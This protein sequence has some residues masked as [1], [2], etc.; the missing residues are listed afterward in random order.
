MITGIK[1]QPMNYEKIWVWPNLCM[2][3][4]MEMEGVRRKV[5][6]PLIGR[7]G[8]TVKQRDFNYSMYP[9]LQ[10]DVRCYDAAMLL[11]DE[12]D[13]TYCEGF[14]Y[15]ESDVGLE[16]FMG[17]GFCVD[18]EGYVIDSVCHKFQGDPRVRYEGIPI[19][20]RYH[21]AWRQHSGY[22]GLLDG[23]PDGRPSPLHHHDPDLWLDSI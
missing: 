6:A 19:Q 23:Y 10:L 3:L 14:M 7:Y 2:Q 8:I 1:H 12:F 20:R 16:Y 15:L 9:A 13:L 11:A 22:Y 4:D 5:A 17:H 21:R 18:S